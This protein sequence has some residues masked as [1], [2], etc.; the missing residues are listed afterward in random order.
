M[1]PRVRSREIEQRLRCWNREAGTVAP[2]AF[3]DPRQQLIKSHI[4][5]VLAS[6]RAATTV[7][8]SLGSSLGLR[9]ASGI[10]AGSS[11]RTEATPA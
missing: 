9:S 5:V 7:I 2:G 1:R 4:A 6:I 10:A 3:C 11:V 8:D